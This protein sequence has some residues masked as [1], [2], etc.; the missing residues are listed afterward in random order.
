[1]QGQPAACMLPC[2]GVGEGYFGT[3]DVV[4]AVERLLQ[5]G[6]VGGWKRRPGEGAKPNPFLIQ[7]PD[8]TV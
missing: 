2:A 4:Q 3:R 1:M 6:G 7:P 5:C 8:H